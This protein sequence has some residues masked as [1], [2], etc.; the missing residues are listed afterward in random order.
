MAIP[1]RPKGPDPESISPVRD[2][3]FRHRAFGAP[4]NDCEI[5]D[6]DYY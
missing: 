1:G 6:G 4:R 3:E 2:Y 5:V